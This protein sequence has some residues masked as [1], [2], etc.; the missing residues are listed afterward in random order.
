M[1]YFRELRFT[2]EVFLLYNRETTKICATEESPD[3]CIQK[4]TNAFNSIKNIL[5]EHRLQENEGK[6]ILLDRK[7]NMEY[8]F[9]NKK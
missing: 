3:L 4:R 8:Y 6:T 2:K 1:D 5:H 9:G 7:D